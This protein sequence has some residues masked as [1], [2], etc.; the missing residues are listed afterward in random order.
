MSGT[1]VHTVY[2][3]PNLVL[4]KE[5]ILPIPL[6]PSADSPQDSSSS[7]DQAPCWTGGR[8]LND[9]WALH[10]DRLAWEL[11]SAGG[12]AAAEEAAQEATPDAPEREGLLASNVLPPCAGHALIPWGSHLLCIG[13]HVKV[14]LLCSMSCAET[15]QRVESL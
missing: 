15:M 2:C 3:K 6:T 12:R 10:V 4:R 7:S 8:Y 9:V 11:V 5:R 1:E 14:E 13:G